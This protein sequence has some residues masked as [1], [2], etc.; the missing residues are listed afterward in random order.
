VKFYSF[1]A[2]NAPLSA[3]RLVAQ[4]DQLAAAGFDG[5]VLQPRFYMPPPEYLSPEWIAALREFCR[6]RPDFDLLIQDENGWPAPSVD[7]RLLESH[8]DLRQSWVARYPTGS[9]PEGAEELCR[10]GEY[11]YVREWG[12]YADTLNLEVADRFIELTYEPYCALDDFRGRPFLG[13]F[14]DEPQFGP[15]DH[16]GR[17]GGGTPLGA[18]AW[19]DDLPA[20]W[21]QRAGGDLLPLLPALF[22]DLPESAATRVRFY[23][24]TADLFRERF[25][26]P[27]ITWC[28]D[29]GFVWTGHFKGEE[30]PYFQLWFCGPLAPLF[31]AM[32]HVGLDML[33]RSPG[34]RYILRQAATLRRQGL[35]PGM[36]ECTGGSG[37]GLTP[38]RL[39]AY[40]WW[41]GL[42]GLDTLVLHQAQYQLTPQAIHDWPPSLP[43]HQPWAACLPALFARLR[44]EL[45]VSR[46]RRR[47]M[48]CW[49]SSLTAA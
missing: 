18:L 21:S 30:H 28:R 42:H 36:I 33:E 19:T 40:L 16:T 17:F 20:L 41:L 12:S 26:G 22:F 39:Y 9:A 4:A 45:G 15:L 8:P 6:A 29:H 27:L 44:E 14:C 25:V 48:K 10:D 1:W 35:G 5:A 13:F 46:L 24:L 38:Q 34:E 7:G 11:V 47:F 2:L 32:G 23:E 43:F 49:S 37:W 3:E 31:R